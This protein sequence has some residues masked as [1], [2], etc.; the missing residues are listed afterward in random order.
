[1]AIYDRLILEWREIEHSNFAIGT[2]YLGIGVAAFIVIIAILL[3][4]TIVLHRFFTRHPVVTR[5][6]KVLIYLLTMSGVFLLIVAGILG[7]FLPIIPGIPLLLAGLLLMRKYHKSVWLEEKIAA[8]KRRMRQY[9]R[10]KQRQR[11][12]SSTKD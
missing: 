9:R 5:A 3:L 11:R 6:R 12:K 4:I 10:R 8:F 2:K 7:L 1:M